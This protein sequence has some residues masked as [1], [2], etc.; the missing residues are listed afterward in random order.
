MGNRATEKNHFGHARHLQIGEVLA[1][2]VE[3]TR[4]LVTAQG[5]PDALTA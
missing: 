1:F 2:A 4:I 5:G 3:I